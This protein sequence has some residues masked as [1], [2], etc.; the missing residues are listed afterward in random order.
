MSAF[1]WRE[2]MAKLLRTRLTQIRQ[3]HGGAG[4]SPARELWAER[5]RVFPPRSPG[6]Q[7]CRRK[8]CRRGEGLQLLLRIAAAAPTMATQHHWH[9]QGS[10]LGPHDALHLGPGQGHGSP[11][12]WE[13]LLLHGGACGERLVRA[14]VD[15]TGW[16]SAS[17]ARLIEMVEKPR[18]PGR[19]IYNL[20]MAA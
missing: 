2:H 15:E 6:L 18:I 16:M 1:G 9:W 11:V 13:E 14:H 8:Q 5:L 4:T 17:N 12:A 7:S 10:R 3:I 19:A 20:Q